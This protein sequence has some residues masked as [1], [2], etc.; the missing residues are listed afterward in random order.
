MV[1]EEQVRGV[2]AGIFDPCSVAARTPLSVLDMGLVS[3][4]TIEADGRVGV[5]MRPTTPLCTMLAC[6]MKAAEE[7]LRALPGVTAVEVRAEAGAGW[8]EAEISDQGRRLLAARRQRSREEVGVQP[9]QWRTQPRPAP[10]SR[11]RPA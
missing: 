8:S 1:G 7:G 5:V 3:A 6:L 2:L 10:S 11:A 9:Q 4:I